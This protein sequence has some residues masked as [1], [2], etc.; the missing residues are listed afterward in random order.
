M[1]ILMLASDAHGGFG[2]IAQYNRD[3]IDTL[4]EEEAID[5]IVIL[6]RYV[7]DPEFTAPRK[8]RYDRAA[9]GGLSA[10]V[11][12]A[13][14]QALF[15]GRFDMIFCAHINLA[16]LAALVRRLARAPLVVAVHGTD[17]WTR[18]ASRLAY[19]SMKSTDLILS[20]SEFTAARMRGW[21]PAPQPR[22]VVVPNAVRLERFGL[23]P[24]A[25]DLVARYG[26]AGKRTIMTLGRMA[27]NERAKG[28]D[29][30]IDIMPRMREQCP[31]LVFLCAG[32]GD[33]R[34]RLE[35]KARDLGCAD[36][37][38]FTGRIDEERKADHFRLADAYIHPSRFEG[39]GIV[40]IEALACG[41]PVVGSTADASEEALLH[42]EL[43]PAVDPGDSEALIEAILAALSRPKHVPERLEF[44]A[45]DRFQNRIR[46][47]LAPVIAL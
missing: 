36:M 16:P 42:G 43:G 19:W 6:P 46:Q 5:E 47:A 3:V 2:G 23:A 30:I 38:K 35:A 11:R 45:Y 28:F 25:P 27:A 31:D 33:D 39:F 18:P 4:A 9:S 24:R 8:V 12:R 34:P 29:E 44:Y 17:V 15:G 41:V 26:L 14:L 40:L 1:R 22:L 13:L 37:V 32:D 20:V 7:E 10:F 21:L